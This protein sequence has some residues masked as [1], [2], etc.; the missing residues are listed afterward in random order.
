MSW[1]PPLFPTTGV[2]V[3]TGV[4]TLPAV[5]SSHELRV[6]EQRAEEYAGEFAKKRFP[7]FRAWSKCQ[8]ANVQGGQEILL[9]KQVEEM[10]PVHWERGTIVHC[11]LIQRL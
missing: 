11:V 1:S 2:P 4:G 10:T 9:D 8:A 6:L 3:L 7:I 5:G